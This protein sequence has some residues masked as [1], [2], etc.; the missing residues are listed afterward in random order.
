MGEM[1]TLCILVIAIPAISG[2]VCAFLPGKASRVVATFASLAT[3]G[4]GLWLIGNYGF[5]ENVVQLGGLAWVSKTVGETVNLFGFIIDPLSSV[6]LSLIVVIGFIIVLYST[7]YIGPGNREHPV[8]DGASRY[9]CWMLFFIASMA[10]VALSSTFFQLFIFWELT[11]LCSWALISFDYE[12]PDAIRAGYKA[13]LMTHV[14]GLFLMT[15][16]V[17][18]FAITRS[19]GFDAMQK[20]TPTMQAILIALMFIG[21]WAKAAQFPF[22]TWLPDAMVAPTPVSAYLH[23]AAM[24]KAGIY[25][26]ARAVLAMRPFLKALHPTAVDTA[27]ILMATLSIITIVIGCYMFFYQDDLK[28]LLAF[29]TIVHLAHIL[30]EWA[31]GSLGCQICY[32]SGLVHIIAHGA[33]KGLLFLSVGALA[34]ATGTRR[35]SELSGVGSKMP[36]VALGFIIGFLTISGLPPFAGFWSKLYF[37]AGAITLGRFGI[38]FVIV[39]LIDAIIRFAWFVWVAHKV[40]ASEPS[41]AVRN[42]SGISL[43]IG[44]AIVIMIL[45]CF[46]STPF[47]IQMAATATG[48]CTEGTCS[49]LP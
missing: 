39:G 25:L 37:I 38:L 5:E 26:P 18:L 4:I 35:I 8:T 42:A 10:G 23:A 7:D 45:L 13:F 28:R 6:M 15:A 21:A 41:E 32:Q 16:I 17:L 14:G 20:L 40:F 2:I 19:F 33:G 49:V 34:Y 31:C 1:V 29:S 47:A 11:T 43:A 27:G 12:D 46:A 48:L 36:L 3:A 24:V 22:H 44:T 9:F 30:M